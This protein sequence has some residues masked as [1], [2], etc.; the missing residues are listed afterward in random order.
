ME[1]VI[2]SIG[3]WAYVLVFLLSAGETAAFVG[4]LLPGETLVIIAGALAGRGRLDAVPLTVA[5]VVG[6]ALGDSLG[7]AIGRWYRSRP[8]A[9]RLLGRLQSGSRGGQARELLGR[10]G[11]AAV[12]VGR[13]IGV[14]RSFVP[15]AAGLTDLPYRRFL[16]YSAA[17]SVI[18]G[19]GSV[20]LGYF[21]GPQAEKVMRAAGATGGAALGGAAVVFVLFL[22][23]RRHFR[24]HGEVVR[25]T[26]TDGDTPR[27]GAV[28]ESVPAGAAS[29]SDTLT[30]WPARLLAPRGR[31]QWP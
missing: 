17:A 13:F 22:L 9:Q 19:T 31:G 4:L 2:G 5:V 15:L 16:P 7:F 23:A 28:A 12:F 30:P 20:L 1:H 21:F 18:W 3:V 26:G 6:G 24:R 29:G 10:R 25:D 27:A 11:G 8:G 14:V